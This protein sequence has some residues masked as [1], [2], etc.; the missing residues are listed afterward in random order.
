MSVT[1]GGLSLEPGSQRGIREGQGHLHLFLM[2]TVGS[3]DVSCA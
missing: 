3:D 1:K 2:M